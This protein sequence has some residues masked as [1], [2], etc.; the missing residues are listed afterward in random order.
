VKLKNGVEEDHRRHA[1]WD[2]WYAGTDEL[3]VLA[4]LAADR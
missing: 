2:R 3:G 4:V 1:E